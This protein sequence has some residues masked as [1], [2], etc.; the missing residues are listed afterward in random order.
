MLNRNLNWS[1]DGVMMSRVSS[2]N[3]ELSHNLTMN[4]SQIYKTSYISTGILSSS[5]SAS[6]LQLYQYLMHRI[7][8][9]ARI[10][11]HSDPSFTCWTMELEMLEGKK[12]STEPSTFELRRTVVE[13]SWCTGALTLA[14]DIDGRSD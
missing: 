12:D 2:Q 13:T 11:I 14:R 7:S 3:F 1:I 9:R 5:Q 4:S 6:W 8:P 10:R